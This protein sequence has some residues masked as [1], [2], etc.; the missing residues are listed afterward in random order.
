MGIYFGRKQMNINNFKY[1]WRFI[2]ERYAKF[3]DIELS[4]IEV[5][6]A[7]I[8]YQNWK[9]IIHNKS[10]VF[11][12]SEY[13]NLIL[14]KKIPM[15]IYDCVWEDN[16]RECCTSKIL[17]EYLCDDLLSLNIKLLYDYHS[18]LEINS[19]LFCEKWSD[20]CYPSDSILIICDSW[21]L[22]YY[23]DVIYGPIKF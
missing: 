10:K 4:D 1:S 13:I 6:S 22:I 16:Q 19:K 18:G 12:E 8:T 14:D 15:F 3:S 7:K 11:E 23:E 5:L 20:F 21:L 2:D 17:S 9:K